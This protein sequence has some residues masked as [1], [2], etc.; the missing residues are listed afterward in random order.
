ML[1]S[2]N[3]HK[4]SEFADFFSRMEIF[5][6]DKIEL[7]SAQDFPEIGT[8]EENGFSYEENAAIK[9]FAWANFAGIPALAD[10][11]GLEVRALG[12]KP[13]IHSARASPGSDADRTRWLLSR[14]ENHGDR[15]ARFVACIVI[16]FPD[17]GKTGH[18][19]FSSRGICGGRIARAS[20]GR[21]GFGYDP[22]FVPD[23]YDVTFA[24]MGSAVKSK[25]SHRAI[26]MQGVA[27]MLKSVIKYY[28]VRHSTHEGYGGLTI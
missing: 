16:A 2:G 19:Y 5:A 17:N 13:G 24:E 4:F 18:G 11:S 9:A 12:W 28:A 8:I 6:E 7:F 15:C 25:I 3:K 27:H 10:D 23:G 22:V 1:A 26:A 21:E 20:K 14:M